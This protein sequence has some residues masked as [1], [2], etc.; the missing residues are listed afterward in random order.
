MFILPYT[1]VYGRFGVYILTWEQGWYIYWKF[2]TDKSLAL[3][4][5]DL[6]MLK[7]L[8]LGSYIC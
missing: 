5:Q 1:H 8:R 7:F 2:I 4:A 6:S 3:R